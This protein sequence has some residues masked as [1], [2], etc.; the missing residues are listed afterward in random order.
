MRPSSRNDNVDMI[1]PTPAI[2]Y[3]IILK[4]NSFLGVEH[5]DDTPRLKSETPPVIVSYFIPP[6]TTLARNR[7]A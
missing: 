7:T 5:I 4:K 2:V 1:H 6:K 3:L